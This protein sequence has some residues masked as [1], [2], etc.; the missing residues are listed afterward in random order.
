M[1]NEKKKEM[2]MK[3]ILFIMF[4]VVSIVALL[5]AEE[6]GCFPTKVTVKVVDEKET[7]V[8]QAEVTITFSNAKA[9]GPGKGWGADIKYDKVKGKTN[10]EG[11]FFASGSTN[12]NVPASAVKDGYYGSSGGVQYDQ[13][14][15]PDK[16][17]VLIPL[18]K[19]L[20]PVPMYVKK[21][22]WIKVPLLKQDVGYDL[23]VGDWVAPHGKGKV[24]DFVFNMDCEINK[25]NDNKVSNTLSFSNREDGIQEYVFDKKDH[26]SY[27][28]PYE[29]P[30]KGYLARLEKRI[31]YAKTRLPF[32]SSVKKDTEIN[33]IFRVRTKLD[34]KRNIIG[35]KYGKMEGEID[36]STDGSIKFTYYFNPSGN[37]SLEF[38]AK[39][40]LFVEGVPGAEDD[41]HYGEFSP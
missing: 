28:W 30:E 4:A 38:D 20:N 15:K 22:D 27:R 26:S 18:K 1:S 23:E 8:D 29:A 17:I 35:A 3:K 12:M 2:K 25:N 9:K 41:P 11:I 24:A 34:E 40:N 16:N 33:Y 39:R 13:N 37:R 36:C 5:I 31:E 7:P 21:T 10:G 14:G 32:F 6:N 19:I